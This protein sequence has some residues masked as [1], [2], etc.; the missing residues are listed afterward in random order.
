MAATKKFLSVREKGERT[1]FKEKTE[2]FDEKGHHPIVSRNYSSL[3][4]KK[5]YE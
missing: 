4:V 2:M 5:V 1:T 3:C